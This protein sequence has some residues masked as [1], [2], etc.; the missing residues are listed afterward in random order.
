MN[1]LT[2]RYF[3]Q[4][5]L[6]II[7]DSGNIISKSLHIYIYIYLIREFKSQEHASTHETISRFTFNTEAVPICNSIQNTSRV[8]FLPNLNI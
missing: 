1:A 2:I 4:M 3:L 5:N 7:Y 6:E 8:T